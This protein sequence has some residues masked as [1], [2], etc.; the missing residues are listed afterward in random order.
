MPGKRRDRSSP[1]RSR[2]LG[3]G[4]ATSTRRRCSPWAADRS[5]TRPRKKKKSRRIGADDHG[6]RR[7]A[8]HHRRRP[9]G[10]G[11]GPRTG[12]ADHQAQGVRPTRSSASRT[13]TPSRRPGSSTSGSTR[14]RRSTRTGTRT[15]SPVP[16][17]RRRVRRRAAVR[18]AARQPAEP[19]PRSRASA[20]VAEQSSNSLLV[21]AN[22]LDLIT[23]ERL[24]NDGDRRRRRVTRRR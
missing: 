20:I 21:R 6:R 18:S 15:R 2:R 19:R 4:S 17:G 13:R 23:I 1:A 12:P 9:E 24:L 5:S 14:S 7:P 16:P 10:R 3:S 11:P 8:H 22:T